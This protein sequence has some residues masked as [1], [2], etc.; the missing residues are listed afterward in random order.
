[1]NTMD[2]NV[3]F[4]AGAREAV[5]VAQEQVSLPQEVSTLAQLRDWYVSRG[6]PWASAL[7]ATSAIRAAVNQ[8]ICDWDTPLQ[9]GCE[10]AFFPPVTGG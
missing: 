1:M 6:Q 7:A 10:V 3:L 8:E 2:I 9:S 4:F 5:G